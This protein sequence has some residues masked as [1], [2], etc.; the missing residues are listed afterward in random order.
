MHN[1]VADYLSLARV[2]NVRCEPVDVGALIE[3][4]ARERHAQAATRRI[5]L[6][7]EGMQT[8]GQ[9][10][11]H[12]YLPPGGAEPGREWARCHARQRS[13]R[14]KPTI[15]RLSPEQTPLACVRS[16]PTVIST[17]G[18]LYGK[19]QRAREAQA[20]LSM[21]IDLYRDMEMMFWLPQ[22]EVVLAEVNGHP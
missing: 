17:S 14:P 4:I 6:H 20:E 3:D 10:P 5:T 12:L 2:S 13:S 21:A 18:I 1:V 11:L 7:L 22:A 8:L 9:L 15:I 19:T 16:R